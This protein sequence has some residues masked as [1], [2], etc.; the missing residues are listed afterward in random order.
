[1]LRGRP[2]IISLYQY[3]ETER[4]LYIKV[5]LVDSGTT[6]SKDT[7]SFHVQMQ[8]SDL[9]Q[10][11]FN[12]MENFPNADTLQVVLEAELDQFETANMVQEMLETAKEDKDLESIVKT[13]AEILIK[14]SPM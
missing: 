12:G 2:G 6:D 13:L 8:Y 10:N 4:R 11:Y 9:L 14:V 3:P 7:V 5:D 1:M